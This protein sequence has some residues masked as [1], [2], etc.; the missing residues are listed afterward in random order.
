ML[1]KL[2]DYYRSSCSYRVR[3]ALNLK[4]IPY[5]KIN[6][7]LIH[8]QHHEPSYQFI[9]PQAAV[10]TWKDEHILL[11][12]SIAILEYLDEQYPDTPS[13]LPHYPLLK[14]RVRQLSLIIACD[15]HPLN[16][17]R[18]KEYLKNEGWSDEKILSWYHH[19]LAQGFDAFEQLLNQFK[20][21][22]SYCVGEQVTMADICLIPQ[23]YNA[24]RFSFDMTPYPLIM[25]IYHRCQQLPAFIDAEPK[26]SA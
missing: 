16:N 25:N 4:N 22:G 9:N 5:E 26:E 6:I 23:I 3:I 10:P 1:N 7:S 24:F 21:S 8:H 11:T 15:I 17:L 18:V 20:P 13:I 12:Q 14:A 19:W 2:Y